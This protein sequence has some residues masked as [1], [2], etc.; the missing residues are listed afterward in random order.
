[1]E[2][3][4][5]PDSW[6]LEGFDEIREIETLQVFRNA[7]LRQKQE[8]LH[9]TYKEGKPIWL[10]PEVEKDYEERVLLGQGMLRQMFLQSYQLDAGVYRPVGVETKFEVPITSPDGMQLWCKCDRCWRK[11]VA[12]HPY[13]VAGRKLSSDP[14][15]CDRWD[16][17]YWKYWKGLP[18]TLGGRIDA[19][20]EDSYG[21]YWVVDWKTAARLSTGEPGSPD[22]FLL[23]DDQVTSYCLAMSILGIDV[24][25]FIY[26]EFKKATP[27][28]PEPLVRTYKGRRYSTNRQKMYDPDVY[29]E[30]VKD[31]DPVAYS[32]GE[33]D[34]F[35]EYL[36][37]EGGTFYKRHVIHRSKTELEQASYNLA[38]EA[39]EMTDA[40]LRIY[41]SPGRYSCNFCAFREPCMATN[42][43]ED[44]D[45]T[46][47]SLF[48][49]REKLYY[50]T[51]LPNTDKSST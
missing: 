10:D 22:D 36:R 50:E 44:V 46:L 20:F 16:G 8:Y 34:E 51:A 43:G 32:R 7:C 26:H 39:A 45:Y 41:P 23:L 3:W 40:G 19:L 15:E 1:M 29:E 35:I 14:V 42:R 48:E 33:Y 9:T 24:A 47:Q 38:M 31:N 28:E 11:W 30:T 37:E 25:G 4:Y 18:V 21:R 17:D 49:K 12:H 6:N 2:H 5:D 27:E 13:E